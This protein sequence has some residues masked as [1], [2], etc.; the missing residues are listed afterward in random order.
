MRICPNP[1]VW[2]AVSRRIDEYSRSH[3]CTPSR[4]PVPLILAGWAYSNDIEKLRRWEETVEWATSNGCEDLVS[5]IPDRDFYSV[6]NPTTYQVGPGGGPMY[7]S[8]DFEAK[9]CPSPDQLERCM[10]TLTSRWLEI[11]GREIGSATRPVG[12]SGKKRRRL[13]VWADS[14]TRP[15]WGEWSKRSEEEV[16]HRTFTRFR[17]AVNDAIAPHEVDHVD[18]ITNQD[19]EGE[20]TVSGL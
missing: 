10:D 19:A 1:Q 9:P 6:S 11:A 20:P 12:F 2:H 13:L 18:F 16:Q 3:P 7:R 5:G 15:P 14:K 17:T 8:W 4:P